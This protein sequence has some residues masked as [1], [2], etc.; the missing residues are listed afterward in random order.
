MQAAPLTD[1]TH[2][3]QDNFVFGAEQEKS[4]EDLCTGPVLHSPDF[5][6]PFTVQADALRR[7]TGAVLLQGQGG[8]QRPVAY[9][10]REI[11][12]RGMGYSAT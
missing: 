10:S 12:P 1:L 2:K 4:F 5:S 9:I 7:G 3:S 8:D 6:L 11:F